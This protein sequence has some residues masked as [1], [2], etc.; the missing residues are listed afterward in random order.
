[1][2]KKVALSVLSATVFASM[3]ASAF[4]AP[5]SGLYIG[6]NVD[7]YYSMNTLFNMNSA[8]ADQFSNELVQAG[9]SNLIYVDFD[10]K[11]ASISEIMAAP[12]FDK[13]KQDLKADKFEGVYSNITADGSADGTYD[14]RKDAID[15]PTGDLKVESVSAING[16]QLEVKFNK[17]VDPA[18]LFVNDED[19][20][21]DANT[22]TITSIESTPVA[23]GTLSGE[24]SEDGKTLTVTTQNALS[25]RY[26]VVINNLKAEDGA[27][28]AKYD[29]VVTIVADTTAPTIVSTVKDSAGSYTVTFSEPV[30]SLGAV[31]YKYA[32]GSAVTAGDVTN[33]FVLGTPTDKVTFT[34]GAGVTAGKTVIATL[35]G[36]Q[37]TA[38]N[39]LNPNPATV[40]FVKGALD[41]VAPT[42][43]AIT[44]TGAKTFTVK[45]SEALVANPTIKI[46]STAVATTDV[47]KDSTDPTVY[48][49]TAPSVLDGATTVAVESFT[50]L[51]GEAG[52]N[53]SKV[54]VFVKD[55]GAPKVTSSNVVVD[56]TDNKQ[57]LEVT[58]DKDV[59]LAAAT[60]DGVG[61]FVKDFVT[62]PVEIADLTATTVD[63]KSAS[64]KKVIRVE[65]DA[66]L[67]ATATDVEGATYTLDLTFAGVTSTAGVAVDT[68]K[69]TF[70]RG[71]DGVPAST[72]VVGVA[73]VAQG[74][75]NNKVEVTFD[76]AVDGASATNA[77]NYKIDGAIVES[78]TLK[79]ASGGTQVAVVNLKAG[80]NE[81]TGT[82]NI[83]ISGVKAL[84]STKTMEPYHTNATSLN[85]NVAP[86]LASAQLVD[87][88]QIVLTFSEAV[89]NIAAG[90]ADFEL[91]IGGKT[92]TTNDATVTEVVAAPGATTLTLTLEDDVTA[93]D[94]A[95]GLSIKALSTIDI[96]DI[97]GNKPVITAPVT[98]Q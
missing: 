48:K 44:Q 1:M 2:N 62:T 46:N 42:V 41:G 77:A 70:T 89:T 58:F 54:V 56:A 14:P 32:D 21:F 78:V 47:V 53:T 71:K 75:D 66:F 7:K 79:A 76:K 6:G 57:Y 82:R 65:L 84:G 98:V 55:T 35:I 51:S 61:S 34:L 95:K 3:A 64:N 43:S 19:G 28:I 92:V 30:K 45:F 17:A 93:D 9:F 50:D 25:K 33:D 96:K 40:S 85:E 27:D 24:L 18:T 86:V 59:T 91:L 67:G 12:D 83:N 60:V 10:G 5:K 16:T 69:V 37:D 94:I 22:V 74:S 88:D 63:Y 13:A 38:S 23:P 31:S 90:G 80:S 73:G 72:D 36:A 4:A 26:N 81:F 49:V 29:E 97:V 15:T 11:G 20:A 8:T 52:T 39:L 87:K 68:S